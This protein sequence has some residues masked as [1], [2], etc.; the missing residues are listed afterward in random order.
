MTPQIELRRP[1]RQMKAPERYSLA[2]NYL[3]LSDSGEL[4]CY[5]EALQ[6]EA[7]AEWEFA[8]DDKIASLMENQTWDLI[9]LSESK[10]AL[11]NLPAEGGE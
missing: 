3:L 2:L 8:M 9:E 5:E 10:R 11:H 7:K 4:E 1:T 6:V